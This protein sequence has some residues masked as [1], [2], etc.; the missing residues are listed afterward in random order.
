MNKKTNFLIY[1]QIKYGYLIIVWTISSSK[2]NV[3][4]YKNI[5]YVRVIRMS[6]KNNFLKY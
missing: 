6:E 5:H 3:K 4:S 1:S 2:I